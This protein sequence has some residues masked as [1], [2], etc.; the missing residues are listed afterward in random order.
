MVSQPPM[1]NFTTLVTMRMVTQR[2]RPMMC[3]GRCR[4]Q[5]VCSLRCWIQNFAIP[6]LDSEKVTNTLIEYMTT[7]FSTLPC[8]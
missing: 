7:S 3:T 8:V 5:S 6:R 2:A 1:A 4:N